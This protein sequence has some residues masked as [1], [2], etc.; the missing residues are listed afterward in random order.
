V[1][2]LC[3]A[4]QLESSGIK[5]AKSISNA[6]LKTLIAGDLWKREEKKK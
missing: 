1:A 2:V 5:S 3:G 6:E 4:G